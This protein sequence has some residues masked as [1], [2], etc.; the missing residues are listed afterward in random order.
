MLSNL[1]SE[2]SECSVLKVSQITFIFDPVCNLQAL[3]KTF[4]LWNLQSNLSFSCIYNRIEDFPSIQWVRL[5]YVPWL[6]R[7]KCKRDKDG[8]HLE[9]FILEHKK[10]SRVNSR[11]KLNSNRESLFFKVVCCY[12]FVG[13]I[14]WV[15]VKTSSLA[16]ALPRRGTK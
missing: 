4:A 13:L 2:V 8:T 5:P 14:V 10:V 16:S 12:A 1:K 7:F 3:A 15:F 6:S 9:G 11:W